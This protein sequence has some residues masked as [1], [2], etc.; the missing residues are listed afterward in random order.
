MEGI[1]NKMWEKIV[2]DINTVAKKVVVKVEVAYP[3]INK[4][5]S[6]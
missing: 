1:I 3:K 4:H 6:E 2:K 5:C